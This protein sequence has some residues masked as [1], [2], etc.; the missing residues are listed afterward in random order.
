MPALTVQPIP[1]TG[2]KPVYSSADAGGD[3]AIVN[4]HVRTFVHIK[5]GHSSPQSITIVG[6]EE[7]NQG[8]TNDNV[9]SV[10]NAEE[11]MI[12][13]RYWEKST[14]NRVDFTYSGVTAL[15]IAIIQV[16]D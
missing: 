3:Y 11:R 14:A 12:P 7:S 4:N 8:E 16:G 15:T 1:E 5:N 2:L 6:V 9:I 10:T 13:I